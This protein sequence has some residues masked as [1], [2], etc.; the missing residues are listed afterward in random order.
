MQLRLRCPPPT[1]T[2]GREGS[3]D[4][5]SGFG[6]GCESESE[7]EPEPE[8]KPQQKQRQKEEKKKQKQ[9][10]PSN[11]S[12]TSSRPHQPR[13]INPTPSSISLPTGKSAGDLAPSSSVGISQNLLRFPQIPWSQPQMAQ[14]PQNVATAAQ[15]VNL[16]GSLDPHYIEQYSGKLLPFS[17]DMKLGD[18]NGFPN[19]LFPTGAANSSLLEGGS[20]TIGST[21]YGPLSGIQQFPSL[22]LPPLDLPFNMPYGLNPI[23]GFNFGMPMA[24]P[25]FNVS[26]FIS[27]APS[28]L[29][30]PSLSH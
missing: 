23:D 4:S 15:N 30:S 21:F 14:L 13:P 26:S 11:A 2:E 25:D 16:I 22:P 10:L 24:L 3:I 9:L 18:F 19:V 28:S 8:L 27:S 7:Y 5:D 1:N 12:V 17:N 20:N 6:F 29:L